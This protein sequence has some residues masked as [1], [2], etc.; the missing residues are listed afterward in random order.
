MQHSFF[1]FFLVLS[2]FSL[3]LAGCG[4]SM[5]HV[6]PYVDAG[7]D[8]GSMRDGFVPPPDGSSACTSNVDC[9]PTP[10]TPVC[11]VASGR[12]VECNTSPDNCPMGELCDGLTHT[13][14]PGCSDDTDCSSPTP[15]CRVDANSCVECLSAGDCAPGDSCLDFTCRRPCD[16]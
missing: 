3:A 4:R 6:D 13:C 8:D 14:V 11:D 10:A 2:F 1:R 7:P 9:A 15:R 5:L 12:C 16:A